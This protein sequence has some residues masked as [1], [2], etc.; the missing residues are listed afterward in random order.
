MSTEPSP[1]SKRR[2]DA[3]RRRDRAERE[4]QDTRARVIDA[5]TRLFVANG[6]TATKMTDI[7]GEAG[8]ALQSVYS[9]GRS[10]AALLHAALMHAVAADDQDVPITERAIFRAI[11]AESDAVRQVHLIADQIWMIQKRS[12][13]IQRAYREAAAVDASVAAS[14]QA[15]HRRRLQTIA[16]A[17]A[18]LPTDRLK[19]PAGDCADS[20]WAIGSN[21]VITLLRTIQG[22]EWD[23]IREWLRRTFVD[24]LLTSDP[25]TQGA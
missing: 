3:R 9:A 5:A 4:R 1:S 11:A 14:L 10:K 25:R 24:A 20:L 19:Y 7:A 2:Y 8:V 18:L 17:I 12:E 15:Q 6:Y 23:T 13:P 21:E 16:A 22:W